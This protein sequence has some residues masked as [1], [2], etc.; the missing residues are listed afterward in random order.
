MNKDIVKQNWKF[1]NLNWEFLNFRKVISK[2]GKFYDVFNGA[3]ND[4][5]GI[6][7]LARSSMSSAFTV[8]FL[9][10]LFLPSH[11]MPSW[12]SS[13]NTLESDFKFLVILVRQCGE[14][15]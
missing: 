11:R 8:Y 2:R 3:P 12:D 14:N 1:D 4:I 9:L 15:V 10:P 13:C 5:N 6:A 7:T